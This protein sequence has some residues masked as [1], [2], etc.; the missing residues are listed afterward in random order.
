MYVDVMNLQA[1]GSLLHKGRHSDAADFEG[2]NSHCL[3]L[4][5]RNQR[6]EE[7]IV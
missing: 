7:E 5:E 2:F 1:T 3:I 4:P 6:R